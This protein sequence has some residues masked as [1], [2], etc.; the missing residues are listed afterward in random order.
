MTSNTSWNSKVAKDYFASLTRIAGEMLDQA[1]SPE[2]EAAGSAGPQEVVDALAVIVDQLEQVSAAIPA[3]SSAPQEESPEAQAPAYPE[4]QP[5]E[6]DPRFA[7]L[8]ELEKIVSRNELEKVAKTYAEL[9]AGTNVQQAKYDEV[10]SSNESPSVWIAKIEA[11][12]SFKNEQGTSPYKPA[13][14]TSSWI[15]SRTKVAKQQ[16]SNGMMRL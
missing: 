13:Q 6:A 16:G 3:E 9:H 5:E 15:P 10:L 14:T 12:E 1:A 4:E 7:R 8:A 11:I 2:G